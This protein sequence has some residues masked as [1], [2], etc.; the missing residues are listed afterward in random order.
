LFDWSAACMLL[1]KVRPMYVFG[2]KRAHVTSRK[3]I[4]SRT[5]HRQCHNHDQNK[6][7]CKPVAALHHAIL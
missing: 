5:S 7:A 6:P 1:K 4:Y 2:P 3:T